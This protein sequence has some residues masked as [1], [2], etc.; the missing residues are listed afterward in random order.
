MVQ[1]RGGVVILPPKEYKKLLQQSMPVH[2]LSSTAASKLDRL[3]TTSMREHR[4]DKTRKINS[5]RDLDWVVI[6]QS[7][8]Y[9]YRIKFLFLGSGHVLFLEIGPHD[10]YR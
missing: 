9:S 1:E 2:Y 10:I 7:I 4:L 5:L 3:V 6:I 8:D